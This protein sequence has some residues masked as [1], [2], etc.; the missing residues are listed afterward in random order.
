M[1]KDC[2]LYINDIPYRFVG[3]HLS[4]DS[5]KHDVVQISFTATNGQSVRISFDPKTAKVGIQDITED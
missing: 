5:T 2:H 3:H 4:W 1:E